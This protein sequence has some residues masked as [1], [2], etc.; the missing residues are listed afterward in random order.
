MQAILVTLPET[1]T[2]KP[3]ILHF[4]NR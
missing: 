3:K 1:V 2:I 4:S